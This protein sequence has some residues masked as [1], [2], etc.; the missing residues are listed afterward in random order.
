MTVYSHSRLATFGQCPLKFRYKYV[1]KLKTDIAQTVEAF[2]GSIVHKV[3]EKLFLD[4]KFSKKNSLEDLL[5]FYK[6]EWKKRWNDEIVIVKK[7]YSEKNYRDMGIEFIKRFYKRHAPFND[8]ITLRLEQ[9]VIVDLNSDGKYKLQG[10]IDRL[11]KLPDGTIEIHDY[12]TAAN[13]PPQEYLE[14]DRQLAL[15]ELAVR[16][17]YPQTRKVVLV[18][19]F[20][21]A[22]EDVRLEKTR[23]ELEKLKTDTMRQI[24]EIRN[25]KA[26]QPK[27]SKLCGWC[28]FQPHCPRRRHLFEVEK[29]PPARFLREDG[30]RLVNRYAALKERQKE[31]EAELAEATASL[32]NYA[33]QHGLENI[34]GSD[35]VAKVKKYENVRFP[36]KT[37]ADR[38]KL[39]E[40][41]KKE[42][43]WEKFSMLDVF[44]LSD[45][46][47]KA[48]IDPAV[49]KKLKK[50]ARLEEVSR[51]YLNKR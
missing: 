23:A 29:L 38:E 10:F 18:W 31:V 36:A 40:I 16:Q 22:D 21:S 1:D 28:E 37:D 12:K 4:L 17:M 6:S 19:H 3:L 9:R 43:L 15:Y 48:E 41:V 5:K 39:E 24:D 33:A 14:R 45:A 42:R 46:V 20:L 26:F 8:S 30:V 2:L 51:V 47:K 44:A 7:D 32:L 13:L 11:A 27:E 35:F 49:I 25:E 34:A 50:F